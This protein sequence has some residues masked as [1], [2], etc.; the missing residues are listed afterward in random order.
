MNVLE[1][2]A[3]ADLEDQGMA[4]AESHSQQGWGKSPWGQIN[5]LWGGSRP[6]ANILAGGAVGAGLGYDAGFLGELLLPREEFERGRLRRSGAVLGAALGA[7]PGFWHT[8]DALRQ[9]A[10]PLSP[11]PPKMRLDG[12]MGNDLPSG[13]KQALFVEALDEHLTQVLGPD[14]DEGLNCFYPRVLTTTITDG[15]TL[16]SSLPKC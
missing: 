2:H 9:G 3:R 4:E 8:Y 16:R 13:A 7:V 11:W 1:R 14:E 6:I 5:A 15:I 10:S 12:A